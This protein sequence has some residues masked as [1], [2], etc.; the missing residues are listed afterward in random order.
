M[1][2]YHPIFK[3]QVEKLKAYHESR[4]LTVVTAS[5][6]EIYNELQLSVVLMA[7]LACP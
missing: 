7:V 1:I 5:V 6:F 3:A 4:G 2:V